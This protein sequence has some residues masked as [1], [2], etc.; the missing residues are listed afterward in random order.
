[1][2][3]RSGKKNRPQRYDINRPRTRHGPKCTKYRLCLSIMI[4]IY[5]KQYLSNTRS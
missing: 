2:E 3:I 4:V 1:M 5:I